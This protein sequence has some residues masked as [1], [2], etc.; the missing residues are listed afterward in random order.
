MNTNEIVYTI[1]SKIYSGQLL[2]ESELIQLKQTNNLY[3]FKQSPHKLEDIFNGDVP[4]TRDFKLFTVQLG[5]CALNG[6]VTTY[7]DDYNVVYRFYIIN[8]EGQSLTILQGG[9]FNELY[10]ELEDI[11]NIDFVNNLELTALNLLSW[12]AYKYNVSCLS[13]NDLRTAMSLCQEAKCNNCKHTFVIGDLNIYYQCKDCARKYPI[14]PQ[15]GVHEC[16]FC[17]TYHSTGDEFLR[18]HNCL[19]SHP[20]VY[21][22]DSCDEIVD[23]SETDSEGRCQRC[24]ER[25]KYYC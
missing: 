25:D 16:S 10:Q 19:K 24:Q 20:S 17:D 5:Y 13:P 14:N 21:Y 18:C 23:L 8:K 3:R 12:F 11:F 2:S 6:Y 22:C 1:N 9:Q 4:L 7:E 15:K